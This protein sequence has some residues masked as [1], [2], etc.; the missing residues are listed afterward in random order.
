MYK[1]SF[2]LNKCIFSYIYICM[3]MFSVLCWWPLTLV[4]VQ[5]FGNILNLV[6]LAESVVKLTAVCMQCFKEAAYTKRL[7]AEK[8]VKTSGPE[9]VTRFCSHILIL[10][11]ELKPHNFCFRVFVSLPQVE[12]IGGADMYH[13][14]CRTCYGGL[15]ECQENRVP[16]RE[17]TPPHA[18]S[19]KPLDQSAPRKLFASLHLWTL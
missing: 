16:P 17:E 2:I 12:V 19:G 14:V 13:A 9:R 8:E 7:G 10:S 4:S 3:Y 18:T 15:R 1:I 5:P 11:G 6:P